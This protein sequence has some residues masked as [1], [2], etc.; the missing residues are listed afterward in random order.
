MTTRETPLTLA[1]RLAEALRNRLTTG[2]LKP[3]ERLSEAALS[4]SFAVSRNTLREVFRLLTM[5]GLLRHEPN[6]GVFVATPS[7]G[8][9][10]DIYRVRR[11]IEGQ[12]L[13]KAY[14]KHPAVARM[15]QAVET[16]LM[17]RE[18][19]DWAGVG[20]ANMLFHAGIVELADSARLSVFY[21]Q[22][23]AELRLCFGLLD[24]PEFLHAPYIGMNAAI[25][26]R[27]DA[28]QP[29][30]A[31]ALLDTYLVQSERTILAAFSRLG[32]KPA[33]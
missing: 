21:A 20:S 26:E 14:P 32:K 33:A 24:D 7:M 2:E 22:V 8:S 15:R 29:G 12:A 10:L 9:I 25:L 4:A 3:G 23:A 11:M 1:Q 5:E 18:K 30:E 16:A 28:G 31:A 6:R 19:A 17:C 13:A 27:L